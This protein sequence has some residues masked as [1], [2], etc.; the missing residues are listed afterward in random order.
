MNSAIN[1]FKIQRNQPLSI[2][3][4]LIKNALMLTQDSLP[5]S[6]WLQEKLRRIINLKFW[7]L[8]NRRLSL[9]MCESVF[10]FNL[11][12]ISLNLKTCFV[13]SLFCLLWMTLLLLILLISFIILTIFIAR[14]DKVHLSY[15]PEDTD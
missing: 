8:I 5:Q 14:F 1:G 9:E 11:S 15:L 7:I 12:S 13:L 6:N 2:L 3:T 10:I 4:S